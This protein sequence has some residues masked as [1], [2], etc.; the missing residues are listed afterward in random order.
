MRGVDK[1]LPKIKLSVV[2]KEIMYAWKEEKIS[3]S[4]PTKSNTDFNYLL[5]NKLQGRSLKPLKL[6]TR[7]TSQ[8]CSILGEL[9][10]QFVVRHRISLHF[11]FVFISQE[12][13]YTHVVLLI[14]WVNMFSG[15]MNEEN[16]N[17]SRM[18]N[19]LPSYSQS[20]LYVISYYPSID[21][22]LVSSTSRPSLARVIQYL[23]LGLTS[24]NWQLL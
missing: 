6:Q 20:D 24:L 7:T 13:R 19:S 8:R 10:F 4:W 17:H 21:R 23:G 5:L 15:E 14:L 18:F 22:F 1:F 12:R 9:V 11:L 3:S 16:N 2:M